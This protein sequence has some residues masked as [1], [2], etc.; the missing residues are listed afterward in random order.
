MRALGPSCNRRATARSH[1][2]TPLIWRRCCVG[3]GSNIADPEVLRGVLAATAPGLSAAD[4]A[5]VGG[6]EAS[7][8]AMGRGAIP[9]PPRIFCAETREWI[10][11]SGA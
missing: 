11:R 8:V 4:L 1:V 6:A 9:T 3:S 10:A 5:A 2:G 7:L